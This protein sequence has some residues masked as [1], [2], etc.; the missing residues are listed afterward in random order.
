MTDDYISFAEIRK[1]LGIEKGRLKVIL[2]NAKIET[3]ELVNDSVGRNPRGIKCADLPVIEEYLYDK[4]KVSKAKAKSI[5]HQL[6][7]SG[8]TQQMIADM[9][10]C[11]Y[12]LVFYWSIGERRMTQSVYDKLTEMESVE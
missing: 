3:F 6:L 10:P 7:L 8:I 4:E 11:H 1:L 9:L 2:N 12:S 5:I